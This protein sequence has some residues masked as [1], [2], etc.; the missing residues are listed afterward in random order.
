MNRKILQ[1]AS[2]YTFFSIINQAINLVAQLVIMRGFPVTQ[3][4]HYAICFEALALLQLVLSNAS[5]NFYLQKI[6]SGS[7]T[8]LSLM[9]YQAINGSLLIIFFGVIVCYFYN[10]DAIVSSYLILGNVLS[11]LLLP[12]Q[13]KWLSENKR[14]LI[15][16]RDTSVSLI[17][18][19]FIFISVKLFN[20]GVETIAITQ[21]IIYGAVPLIFIFIF[22]RDIFFIENIKRIVRV[23]F[24]FESSLLIF[25]LIFFVNALHN[26]YGG[27]F[28][29]NFSDGFQTAIYLATFKFIN[30]LFFIQTSLISAFMP[31]FI[32]A[33]NFKFDRK[34]FLVFALPG[35]IIALMLFIFYPLALSILGIEQYITSYELIKSGCL[36]VFIVFVYGAMSNYISISGGQNYI[37]AVNILALSLM[38]VSSYFIVNVKFTALAL[39]HIFVI[40]ECLICI[41]Y[42]LYIYKKKIEISFFFFFSPLLALLVEFLLI[43]R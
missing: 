24:R 3:F 39:I 28:L 6:K 20:S 23:K 10:L 34:V 40:A 42:F 29:R 25:C 12:L 32:K 27:I 16:I 18:L 35:F 41:L 8:V 13:A 5:R 26:K 14:W 37:L 4:G 21:F 22:Q 9:N 30:P 38:L 15:I 31:S 33:D 2:I 17:S 36:F 43:V 19:S 7:E 11:S 1:T